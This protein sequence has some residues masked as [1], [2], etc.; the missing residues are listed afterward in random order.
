MMKKTMIIG[1]RK[2][3]KTVL[4]HNL[5]GVTNE[6]KQAANVCY[7]KNSLYIPG[8]YLESPWM[9]SHL[10]ALQ[11]HAKNIIM[12][13]SAEQS[14]KIYPPNFALSFRVPVFGV[15]SYQN[16]ITK[17][18]VGTATAELRRAGVKPP[19]YQMNVT[20]RSSVTKIKEM[21]H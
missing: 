8:T 4:M 5:D 12:I 17:Q 3:G 15:I 2:S 13:V 21:I 16:K 6:K 1:P 14:R 20:D 10:I 11:Q 18:A 7:G 19:Y 9:Y